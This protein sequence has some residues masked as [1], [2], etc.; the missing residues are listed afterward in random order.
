MFKVG[1]WCI[2]V[3]DV[4]KEDVVIPQGTLGMVWGHCRG[5]IQVDW[6]MEYGAPRIVNPAVLELVETPDGVEEPLGDSL[7]EII[8]KLSAS[9]KAERERNEKLEAVI[10][11]L[12]GQG[13]KPAP[14]RL[15][16]KHNGGSN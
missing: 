4:H 11:A 7:V 15:F 2:N 10:A 9:L 13:F 12:R 16:E 1:E 5:L 3:I 6:G 8:A 14:S